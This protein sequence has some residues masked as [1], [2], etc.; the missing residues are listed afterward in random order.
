MKQLD[1][2]QI[3]RFVS[4]DSVA[5]LDELEVF[6]TIESTN[7]YLLDCPPPMP[8]RFRVVLTDYQTAG[9]GRLGRRWYSPRSSGLIMSLA[10][11][12]NG[13]PTDISTLTLATGVGVAQVFQR[14]GV[15]DIGLKWPNDIIVRDGKLGGILTEVKSV[16]GSNRT[17]ILGVGINY[18]L[19]SVKAPDNRSAWLGSARDLAG[20]LE[21]LPSRSKIFAFL[22]D[23]LFNTLITFEFSGFKEFLSEW[24]RLDWLSGQQIAV[25][26]SGENVSGICEGIGSKGTLI[27]RTDNGKQHIASGSIHPHKQQVVL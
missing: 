13:S 25:E 2:E 14:L 17:V 19:R 1:A 9:Y 6:A 27:L 5:H 12:F 16:R 20:C 18:D 21:I 11:T 10:Y 7:S 23:A 8:G 24:Q 4:K 15:D 22:V 3:R 26:N